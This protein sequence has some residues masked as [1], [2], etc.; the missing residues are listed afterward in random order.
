MSDPGAVSAIA[1]IARSVRG[2]IALAARALARR[3]E[4]STLIE[5]AGVACI[6]GALVYMHAGLAL[7]WVGVY[8]LLEAAGRS[9]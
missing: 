9:R 4:V 2:W 7:A 8:L 5:L 1:A 3:L 6:A